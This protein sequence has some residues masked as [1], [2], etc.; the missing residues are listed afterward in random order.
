MNKTLVIGRPGSGKSFIHV[1]NKV[2][3][4]NGKVIIVNARKEVFPEWKNEVSTI[5]LSELHDLQQFDKILI[6]TD[7]MFS[8]LSEDEKDSLER[9]ILKHMEEP[10]TLL[11]FEECC[12]IVPFLLPMLIVENFQAEVMLVAQNIDQIVY[13]CYTYGKQYNIEEWFNKILCGVTNIINTSP[14]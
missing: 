13:C 2:K 12:N 4:H 14:D 9:F 11:V 8:P 3:K 5:K 1:K 7:K 10:D 6:H